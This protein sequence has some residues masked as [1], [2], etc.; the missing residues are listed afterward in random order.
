MNNDSYGKEA[1]FCRV[2]E[3]TLFNGYY[4]GTT[5]KASFAMEKE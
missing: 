4:E 3:C 2:I 1:I 5:R